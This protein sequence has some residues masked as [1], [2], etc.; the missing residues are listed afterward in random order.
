MWNCTSLPT[1]SQ[2]KNCNTSS[3]NSPDDGSATTLGENDDDEGSLDLLAP[4]RIKK[5]KRSTASARCITT[6]SKSSEQEWEDE[7]INNNCNV[8]KVISSPSTKRARPN[9]NETKNSSSSNDNHDIYDDGGIDWNSIPLED[10][11]LPK[12]TVN[13]KSSSSPIPPCN[14][15]ATTDCSSTSSSHDHRMPSTATNVILLSRPTALARPIE[16]CKTTTSINTSPNK[17]VCSPNKLLTIHNPY[18]KSPNNNKGSPSSANNK[19]LLY[20]QEG[21]LLPPLPPE[22][23]Y[24]PSRIQPFRPIM[25]EEHRSLVRNANIGGILKN[26]WKLMPHQ[27]KAILKGIQMRR[28]LV[29]YDMGLGK[30]VLACVWANAFQKTFHLLK[31]FVIAPV[32]LQKEWSTT[33]TTC[34]DLDESLLEVASWGKIPSPPPPD[35]LFVVIADEAH[36]MQSI[37]S[38]RTKETLALL[39]DPRCVGCLLLTGTPMKNGKPANLFPLL[40]GIRHPLGDNQRAYETHFCNGQNKNFGRK[41]GVVWDASG[42]SNLH[43]L[44]AHIASHVL[45]M[46][47]EEALDKLCPGKTRDYRQIQV[48]SKYEYQYRAKLKELAAIVSSASSNN[49]SDQDYGEA[50][51]GAFTRVRQIS[52]FSK[53]DAT[54]A[55]AQ[56]ILEKEPSIVIFTCF[57][58]VAKSVHTKLEESGWSGELL[59]GQTPGKIRQLMVDNFQSG[60]LSVFV[61][62]FGAGGVGLTLTAACTIILLDRPWTPGDALQAEDRVR[63]IGQTKEVTSIWMRAFDIDTQIDELI[64]KRSKIHTLWSMER[65]PIIIRIVMQQKYSYFN[66]W[67]P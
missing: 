12:Y 33:A 67:H 5:A 3:T 6:S 51:L 2:G 30:T 46:T 14:K 1:T 35:M 63:R 34:T 17:S 40:K 47:K 49:N 27:K 52:S 61:C 21:K 31:V 62:T 59:T 54:V 64:E 44:H 19:L 20:N 32:S 10:Y 29:A 53:I 56:S 9:D 42:S 16:W 38:Q 66:S 4:R 26:G 18:D 50:L 25:E 58:D 57:V 15:S 28:L 7:T 55:L 37:A 23:S 39:N 13:V 60:V 11:D 43:V 8:E 45:H 41:G 36:S 65:R 22:L 48:S 24:E